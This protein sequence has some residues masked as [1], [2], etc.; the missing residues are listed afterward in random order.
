MGERRSAARRTR[1]DQGGERRRRPGHDVRR[2]REPARR[3]R[4][5]PRS[6]AGSARPA[7]SSWARRTCRSSASGPSPSRSRTASPATRG[8]PAGRP[9]GSSGGTAAAVA[10]GLVAVGI[11][12]DGGGSIRIP[13]ACCG[14]FGLKPPRGRVTSS[15][16]AHGWWGAGHHRAAD[17][18]RAGQRPRLRRHPRHPARSTAGGSTS[19]RRPSP[20][21]STLRS[22]RCGWAGRP[23]PSRSACGPTLSTSPPSRDRH[24]AGAAR[25]PRRGDRPRLPGPDARVRAAVLRRGAHRRRRCRAP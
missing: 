17:P 19:R 5:T 12:G 11:G 24:P 23:G 1:R 3:P 20:P 14:L 22:H 13:S 6:C 15:P 21:R 18:L 16:H 2:L 10:A 7:P 25:P 9:G 4:Q 8:T